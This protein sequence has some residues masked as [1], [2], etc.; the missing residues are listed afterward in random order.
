MTRSC[1]FYHM[2][3]LRFI[4]IREIRLTYW[5]DGVLKAPG[6]AATSP[7]LHYSM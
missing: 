5:R 1:F 7:T 6:N 2:N 4:Y 3:I